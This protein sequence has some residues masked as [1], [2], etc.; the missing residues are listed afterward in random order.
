MWKKSCRAGQATDGF[1]L[2]QCLHKLSS[3]LHY[4]YTA[5]LVINHECNT[6]AVFSYFEVIY[7]IKFTYFYQNLFIDSTI[8][9]LPTG[10]SLICTSC[11]IAIIITRSSNFS[12]LYMDLVSKNLFGKAFFNI[13]VIN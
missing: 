7:L 4:T 5:Y 3:I 10:F 12:C 2:Q 11:Y 9:A 6:Y 1:Q 13:V 8:G